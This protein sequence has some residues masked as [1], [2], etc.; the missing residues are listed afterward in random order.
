MAKDEHL[1]VWA[2]HFAEFMALPLDHPIDMLNLIRFRAVAAYPDEHS[3]AGKGLS[4]EEAFRIY[5]RESY[6]SFLRA[7]GSMVWLGSMAAMLI[8]PI[9]ERWNLAFIARY[10]SREAFLAS[11][12]DPEY[13]VA[14]L[15]RQAALETS[16]LICLKA[17]DPPPG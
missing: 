3:H 1:E 8:G 10:P 15:H 13:K 12:A 2:G 7:G 17:I 14:V 9:T 4:G 5:T 16:R 11:L 6:P